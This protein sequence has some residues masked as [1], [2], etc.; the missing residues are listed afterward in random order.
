MGRSA[1][2]G[3]SLAVAVSVAG[4]VGGTPG[5]SPEPPPATVVPAFQRD[6]APILTARCVSC[7]GPKQQESLLRLD[8]RGEA[9]KG[10]LSGAV[11][12]PGQSHESLLIQHLTGEASPRMPHEKPP[13]AAAQI[14]RIAAWIDAGAKGPDVVAP[15][16]EP[17]RLTGRTV[18]PRRPPLPP[19]RDA[20]GAGARS[21]PSCWRGSSEEGLAPSPEA[22]R[23]TLLSGALTLDLTGLPPT[24]A[25]I[26]AFLADERPD[27]YERVVDRLLASPRI[28][29]ALGAAVARPGALRRHQR[30]REG[31]HPRRLALPRLGDRGLQP[32]PAV[33][34]LHDRAARRRP[35]ARRDASSSA[36]PPG[37]TATR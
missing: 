26:D 35:A 37:S 28:R 11:I 6:I 25:E 9:L 5:D 29:R 16:A 33:R 7:H 12:V 10:G 32:R 3:L 31:Q 20:A 17:T 14:A 2:I 36:S 13:L 27:A 22:A 23:A 24:P 30:L 21:T 18:K 1:H 19:V 15:D 4:V 34:P 8:T